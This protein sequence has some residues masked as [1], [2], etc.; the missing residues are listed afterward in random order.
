MVYLASER[1]NR[2]T[3]NNC[4]VQFPPLQNKPEAAFQAICQRY[5]RMAFMCWKQFNILWRLTAAADRLNDSLTTYSPS[6]LFLRSN[7]PSSH[8][9]M[10]PL[11][12]AGERATRPPCRREGE[13]S[14]GFVLRLR[15]GASVWRIPDA[16]LTAPLPL[17]VCAFLSLSCRTG[18]GW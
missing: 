16:L 7:A 3:S 5:E 15:I 6:I 9:E 2:T 10:H 1:A 4:C 18:K 13:R 11:R 12:L 17:K 8:P 14:R